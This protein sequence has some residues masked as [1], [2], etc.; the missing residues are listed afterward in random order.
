M[1]SY[2]I[3]PSAIWK[4]FSFLTSGALA[5]TAIIS[6]NME[7]IIYRISNLVPNCHL[8]RG[9]IL[10]HL[11]LTF[12][13]ISAVMKLSLPCIIFGNAISPSFIGMDFMSHYSGI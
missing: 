3:H 10:A 6:C 11:E 5:D 2:P 7:V 8:S 9:Y 13:P 12:C 1:I 4:D